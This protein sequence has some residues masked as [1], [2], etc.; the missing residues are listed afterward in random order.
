MLQQTAKKSLP[1]F[2][3]QI[4]VIKS[5]HTH[6]HAHHIRIRTDRR[7]LLLWPAAFGSFFSRLGKG[8]AETAAVAA[9]VDNYN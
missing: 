4:N 2:Y 5:V 1:K 3:C 8:D 6:T 9:A 7:Q